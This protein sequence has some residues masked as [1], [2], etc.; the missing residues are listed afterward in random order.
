MCD[1]PCTQFSKHDTC[2]KQFWGNPPNFNLPSL[3]TIRQIVIE[4]ESVTIAQAHPKCSNV[5]SIYN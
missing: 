4:L 5:H 1:K 3:S 2:Q